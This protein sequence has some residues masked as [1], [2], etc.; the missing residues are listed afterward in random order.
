MKYASLQEL[1]TTFV[2]FL[3]TEKGYSENTCRA[4]QHDL[5]DFIAYFLANRAVTLTGGPDDGESEDDEAEAIDAEDAGAVSGLMIRSYLGFLHKQKIKKSS[6]ARK[7]S[8]IRSFMRFLEKHGVITDNPAESVIT[9]KQDKPIPNYLTVDDMFRLLD[10]IATENLSGKRNRAMFE[11]LY[12]TG[13]RVSE[14]VGLDVGDVDASGRVIRVTG[15]GNRER[16]APIGQKALEWI[17]EY[18]Q[19]LHLQKGIAVNTP[20]PLFLNKDNERLTT[21]S[22]AR[23]L[24]KTA[25]EA[26]LSTPVAPHDIR[27]SFATHLLDAG[28]DLRVVQEMLGHKLLSTTQKYTHV[29]IDRLMAAYD[30]AHPRK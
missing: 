12:S 25:L 9:P 5:E 13:I 10:S 2:D 14:L 21:R 30:A 1:L 11:T 6:V 17:R 29:S 8:A 7:L 27:H 28:L 19:S 18:R 15:K 20:G 4:Y 26:G 3:S 24:E 23:I 22:V 16:M